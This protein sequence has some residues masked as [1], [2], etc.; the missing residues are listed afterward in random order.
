ME[1]SFNS[2]EID[3]IF[4]AGLKDIGLTN[5]NKESLEVTIKQTR[6][7]G[8]DTYAIVK[9]SKNEK[10]SNC[11]NCKG[12]C[13]RSEPEEILSNAEYETIIGFADKVTNGASGLMESVEALPDD[14]D[15]V[16]TPPES[17]DDIFS[18]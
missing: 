4:A 13:D 15:S 2:K 5:I 6:G 11:D 18:K 14:D 3:S 17:L 8:G 12:V 9:F 10:D 16:N 7:E 1:I